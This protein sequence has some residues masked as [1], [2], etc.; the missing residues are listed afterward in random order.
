VLLEDRLDPPELDQAR[1]RLTAAA[2]A[3]HTDALERLDELRQEIRGVVSPSLFHPVSL[4]V[5]S[6]GGERLPRRW[7]RGTIAVVAKE[8]P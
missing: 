3:G 6:E 1:R 5:R 8:R 2:E 4:L 7:N